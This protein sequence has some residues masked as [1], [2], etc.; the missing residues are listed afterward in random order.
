[1]QNRKRVEVQQQQQKNNFK[2]T[3]KKKDSLVSSG[4]KME[5][6]ALEGSHVD[7]SWSVS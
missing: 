6:N 7:K 2:Q 4:L 1:M 5:R 3:I